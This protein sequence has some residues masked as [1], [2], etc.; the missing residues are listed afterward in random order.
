MA[1]SGNTGVL[2]YQGGRHR[3][4]VLG[5]HGMN[6]LDFVRKEEEILSECFRMVE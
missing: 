4:A 1:D 2:V 3:R 6:M 5:F